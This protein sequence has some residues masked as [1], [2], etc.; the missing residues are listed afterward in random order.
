M[1]NLAG[2]THSVKSSHIAHWLKWTVCGKTGR[3]QA[4]TFALIFDYV[5]RGVSIDSATL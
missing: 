2:L 4:D 5:R 1:K 3:A